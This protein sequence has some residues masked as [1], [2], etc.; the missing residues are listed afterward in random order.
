MR[1]FE[2]P[3][4][5]AVVIFSPDEG[6][7]FSVGMGFG[8]EADWSMAQDHINDACS[9]GV[10][11]AGKWKAVKMIS[12]DDVLKALREQLKTGNGRMEMLW[13]IEELA[14]VEKTVDMEVGDAEN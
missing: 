10:E 11:G 4:Y 2:M 6:C 3:V 13:E 7:E 14:G 1:K 5:K 9:S 12:I 8:T